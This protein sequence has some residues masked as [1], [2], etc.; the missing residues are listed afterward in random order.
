MLVHRLRT[1]GVPAPAPRRV[2]AVLD[3]RPGERILQ[4]RPG[5]G[6]HAR[7]VADRLG[8]AGRLDLVDIPAHM[9]DDAVHHLTATATPSTAPVVP[10]VADPRALPFADH[11]FHAAYL[12]GA[13][14]RLPDPGQ[15]LEEIHRVLRPAG[16]LVV[17]DHWHRHWLPPERLR[18]LARH[19]GF[20]TLT[21]TGTLRYVQLL[22]PVH[23]PPAPA[24]LSATTTTPAVDPHNARSAR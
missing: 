12:V 3:P 14:H 22:Q 20:T 6:R 17:A 18:H 9:L 4:I 8:P 7:H 5:T 11:T 2:T 16:R 19:H 13:L 21:C 24:A 23:E 15:A 1:T 10:T